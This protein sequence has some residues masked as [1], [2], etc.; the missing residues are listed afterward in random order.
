MTHVC[1]S[2]IKMA[3]SSTM[4]GGKIVVGEMTPALRN[5]NLH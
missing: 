5:N 1:A 3:V 2:K 4:A